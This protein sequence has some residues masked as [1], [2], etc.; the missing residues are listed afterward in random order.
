MLDLR[1]K[2]HHPLYGNYTVSI[3]DTISPGLDD[4]VHPKAIAVNEI[5]AKILRW[6]YAKQNT[7]DDC[8]QTGSYCW[9]I[10]REWCTN[11]ESY[12]E[13]YDPLEEIYRD[14]DERWR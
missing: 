8:S 7:W 14:A 10:S 4:Y 9:I 11:H 3:T 5:V 1:N 12:E 6:F 2:P 13:E